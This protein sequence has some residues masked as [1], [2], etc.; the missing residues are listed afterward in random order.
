M[1]RYTDK[2]FKKKCHRIENYNIFSCIMFFF[3]LLLQQR[4]L[5]LEIKKT[6]YKQFNKQF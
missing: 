6:F 5:Y 2:F 1:G 3:F 4:E